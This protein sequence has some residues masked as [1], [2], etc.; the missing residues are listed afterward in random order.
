MGDLLVTIQHATSGLW[1]PVVCTSHATLFDLLAPGRRL[2]ENSRG[3]SPSGT[4]YL[5]EQN[6]STWIEGMPDTEDSQTLPRHADLR[7]HRMYRRQDSRCA[8]NQNWVH[9][10]RES[11]RGYISRQ[12]PIISSHTMSRAT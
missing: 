8:A 3:T 6:F 4:R 1:L 2:V 10:K 11:K 9:E 5:L 7:T 12:L